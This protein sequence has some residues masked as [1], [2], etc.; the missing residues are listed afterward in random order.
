MIR[1]NFARIAGI[2]IYKVA[3]RKDNWSGNW[4]RSGSRIESR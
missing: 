1:I 4:S 2:A 3:G